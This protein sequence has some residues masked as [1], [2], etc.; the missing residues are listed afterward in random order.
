MLYRSIGGGT[1]SGF[2][3]LLLERLSSDYGKK[4]RIEFAVLPSLNIDE[5]TVESYNTVFSAHQMLEYSDCSI[6]FNNNAI[7]D[8]CR[9]NLGLDRCTHTNV[10]RIIA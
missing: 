4:Q 5:T 2:G 10:N 6:M 8:I 7:S 9:T 1:G 3:S